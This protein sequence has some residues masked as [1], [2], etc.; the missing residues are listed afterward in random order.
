MHKH[1]LCDGVRDCEGG[2]D[3]TREECYQISERGCERRVNVGRQLHNTLQTHVRRELQIPL[4]WLGDGNV[5]CIGNIIYISCYLD[6]PHFIDFKPFLV[7]IL[8][9]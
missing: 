2:Q 1:Q 8:H 4:A 6:F 7:G 3:E 5:D 9:R